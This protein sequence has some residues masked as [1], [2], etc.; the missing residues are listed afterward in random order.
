MKTLHE[1]QQ[2]FVVEI[3]FHISRNISSLSAVFPEDFSFYFFSPNQTKGSKKK[4]EMKF[5]NNHK[6]N[7]YV[8]L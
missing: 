2:I 3:T 5:L 1:K 7:I 6:K 4:N 8:K